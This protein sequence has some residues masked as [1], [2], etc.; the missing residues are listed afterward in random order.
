MTQIDHTLKSE[1][2]SQAG[3][4]HRERI[5]YWDRSRFVLESLTRDGHVD[6]DAV[7]QALHVSA[8]TVRRDLDGLARKQLLIRIRGG[9]V[10][11]SST[12]DLPIF[13]NAFRHADEKRRIAQ[14]AAARVQP[15][16]VIGLNGGTTTTEIARA[17]ALR[18]DLERRDGSTSLTIVTNAVNIAHEL[19]VRSQF[20]LVMTGGNVRPES[21]E[22]F[23]SLCD[24]T[25]S[26]LTFD[27]VL[28]SC[29]GLS[30]LAGASCN[31]VNEASTASQFRSRSKRATLVVDAS[32]FDISCLARVCR[33]EDIDTVISDEGALQHEETIRALAEAGVELVIARD[34]RSA[35]G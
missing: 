23:G 16:M 29:N 12:Y 5:S 1:A 19:T 20:Q 21:Y 8:A 25:L 11:N 4:Q 6:I 18:P 32:K 17:L 35:T 26:H 33:L 34:S 24:Q 28:L 3:Q 13:Y 22:T 7:A 2:G 14:A 31:N 30:A 27:E 9:A 10:T 15:G